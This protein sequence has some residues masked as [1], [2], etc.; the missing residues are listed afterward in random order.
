VSLGD[1]DVGKQQADDT[2]VDVNKKSFRVR[3]P[4]EHVVTGCL[5]PPM[6]WR[7]ADQCSTSELV[8]A[9]REACRQMSIKPLAKLVQQLEAIGSFEERHELLS[10]KGENIDTKVCE[11]LEE[12]FRRVRFRCIDIESTSL[13]EETAV[14]MFD[15]LDYYESCQ[16]LNISY[17][18]N[19]GVRGW[20]AC[21]RFMKKTATLEM[22]EARGCSFTDPA[23]TMIGRSLRLG[24]FV[25]V[26]H[27]ESSFLSGRPLM[28]LV[29]A[30]KFNETLRELFLADNKLT[31][32]DGVQLGSLLK[33]NKTL[34]LLDVR[35]NLLQ[36]FGLQHVCDGILEH[37]TRSGLN[38]LVVWNNQ[39]TFES[40]LAVSRALVATK[41]L[42]TLNLGH[43]NITN[44]GIHRLKDGL[45]QN[46]SLLRIGLQSAKISCEGAV[47][48][49]E[50]IAES[51]RLLRLDLR[52]NHIRTGGL[53][54]LTLSL[55]VNQSVTRIDLDPEPKKEAG[56]RDYAEQQRR[57][58]SDIAN[59]TARNLAILAGLSP[60]DNAKL[61]ENHVVSVNC[62][63]SVV[64]SDP[65]SS[66]SD[67]RREPGLL[68]DA[69]ESAEVAEVEPE[70]PEASSALNAATSHLTLLLP[71]FSPRSETLES[72]AYVPSEADMH[73]AGV[74]LSSVPENSPD[75]LPGAVSML[76]RNTSVE[77]STS[78]SS[79]AD[80]RPVTLAVPENASNSF[81]NVVSPSDF[82]LQPAV[83][84][85][86][87]LPDVPMPLVESAL[88]LAV[89][90]V[91]PPPPP[92]PKP[93]GGFAATVRR[94]FTV[95]KAVLP[96]MSAAKPSSPPIVVF[97]KSAIDSMQ[98]SSGE[99]TDDSER[100]C[101]VDRVDADSLV[102]LPLRND[103][104]NEP[105]ASVQ[106]VASSVSSKV[107]GIVAELPA[108]AGTQKEQSATILQPDLTHSTDILVPLS[109]T[110]ILEG[111]DV[112]TAISSEENSVPGISTDEPAKAF[113]EIFQP[114]EVS[115]SLLQPMASLCVTPA[116]SDCK[117]PTTNLTA[118]M[119][120][121]KTVLDHVMQCLDPRADAVDA[122]H[123]MPCDD[124]QKI[125]NV[126]DDQFLDGVSEQCG[127]P[128]ASV[129]CGTDD[130]HPAVAIDVAS[131]ENPMDV[132][133]PLS[134]STEPA[135]L[136]LTSDHLVGGALC[137]IRSL[138]SACGLVS[139][140]SEV[141]DISS[142][143][144]EVVPSLTN[145]RHSCDEGEPTPGQNNDTLHA[146]SEVPGCEIVVDLKTLMPPPSKNDDINEDVDETS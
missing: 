64:V 43:N 34:S 65:P 25:K 97:K 66:P 46:K 94:K 50:F 136:G 124:N 40:M 141:V 53:M 146:A 11:T 77:I 20:Q 33:T 125:A 145:C 90:P 143:A 109:N 2:D 72:P 123:N 121:S 23:M 21:A 102:R 29:A 99:R 48:L 16:R 101:I 44:E 105:L 114:P 120:S 86:P 57:L 60:A 112:A 36:D 8:S 92:V 107:T 116:G 117:D 139:V 69:T 73:F 84:P 122:T 3:F 118:E 119:G 61:L 13:E 63:S 104:V 83:E 144:V 128:S 98:P 100:V 31:P 59:Y 96:S 85:T 75:E 137:N 14:I 30:I 138:S 51:S 17:N 142:A 95:S 1:G 70:Q 7:E 62:S 54:A 37:G 134:A 89:V 15:L 4:D 12:V 55:K 78:M 110:K 93:S 76:E 19:L 133:D 131:S 115:L 6:P 127:N 80:C 28:L 81:L 35:N 126:S 24:S 68:S 135:A 103:V 27:F 91:P 42:E 38:T 5:D 67:I 22:L 45:L 56:V 41:A 10:L 111:R 113:C 26:L 49:A 130:D 129:S 82:S 52:G 79:S 88:P 39:V 132:C 18:K 87:V 74:H 106:P 47:A 9:Y 58:L 32:S 71:R 108:E 140:D